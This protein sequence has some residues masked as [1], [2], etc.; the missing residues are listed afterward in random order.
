VGAGGHHG[1]AVVAV[2]DDGPGQHYDVIV[3]EHGLDADSRDLLVKVTCRIFFSCVA[4]H[5]SEQAKQICAGVHLDTEVRQ[6]ICVRRY[7]SQVIPA[8]D[9][10]LPK[11]AESF[12]DMK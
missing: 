2:S 3:V 6:L 12:L 10:E 7:V 4:R 9:W 5:V 1:G 11:H 8:T